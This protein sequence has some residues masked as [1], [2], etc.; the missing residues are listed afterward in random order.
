MIEDKEL[1]LKI[2]ENEDVALW[3]KIRDA[4][5]AAIKSYEEA[6]KAER[7]FLKTAV[8]MVEFYTPKE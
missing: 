3:T 8:R 7:E 6:L 2:A 5:A 1:N 4:R